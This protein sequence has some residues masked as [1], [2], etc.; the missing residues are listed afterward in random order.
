[1]SLFAGRTIRRGKSFALS[2]WEQT[3]NVHCSTAPPSSFV[4]TSVHQKEA[5]H[6]W[7]HITGCSQ[8]S[9]F[10]ERYPTGVVLYSEIRKLPVNFSVSSAC[11]ARDWRSTKPTSKE[12]L[13]LLPQ[14]KTS[15]VL[16]AEQP[17]S[18]S[19]ATP[20]NW[21]TRGLYCIRWYWT[22][23]CCSIVTALVILCHGLN[24]IPHFALLLALWLFSLQH[25]Y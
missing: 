6:C 17:L 10:W 25:P 23:N 11:A 22:C 14:D 12:R 9:E 1:M 2:L 16:S 24:A 15:A 8:R 3:D 18:L 5:D 19:Q 7:F 13:T 20:I 4:L 21:P